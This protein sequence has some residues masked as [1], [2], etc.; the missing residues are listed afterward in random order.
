MKNL[1]NT[2]KSLDSSNLLKITKSKIS[3]P[4]NHGLT[5]EMVQLEEIEYRWGQRNR[6]QGRG[7][8]LTK[9]L[10]IATLKKDHIRPM[11]GFTKTRERGQN[12]RYVDVFIPKQLNTMQNHFGTIYESGQKFY[13][14]YIKNTNTYLSYFN[15]GEDKHTIFKNKDEKIPI[16]RFPN[17]DIV[18]VSND[19]FNF[20]KQNGFESISLEENSDGDTILEKFGIGPHN[21]FGTIDSRVYKKFLNQD[22]CT[23]NICQKKKNK[24]YIPEFSL[25]D[26]SKPHWD[27]IIALYFF[28]NDIITNNSLYEFI[29]EHSPC[30]IRRSN[31]IAPFKLKLEENSP[32]SKYIEMYKLVLDKAPELIIYPSYDIP[33]EY[34]KILDIP[35]I[36]QFITFLKKERTNNE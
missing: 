22:K 5:V 31:K 1:K 17:A 28:N 18:E 33:V 23:L 21:V 14:K 20:Y 2:I 15:F 32:I 26:V 12:Y 6:D 34:L 30:S 29:F 9:K 8:N 16:S 19:V 27:E 35:E 3:I 13:L 4:L 11:I 7:F 24:E 36:S 10:V 25:N